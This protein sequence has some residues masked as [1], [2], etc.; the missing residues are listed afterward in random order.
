VLLK[1]RT[2]GQARKEFLGIGSR[3]TRRLLAWVLVVGALV[4]LLVS[5]GEAY[6]TYRERLDYLQAHL[7]SIGDFALPTLTK[8][9]WAYD[10]EQ[11][12][13]QLNAF[14]RLP[15]VDG[16][17]L[18]QSDGDELRVGM[19]RL[20]EDTLQRRFEIAHVD[21]GQRTA[22]GSL[23][24]IT[25]LH[26]DRA[27]LMR[28]IA[29]A[30]AGNALIILVISII[31]ALL[32]HSIVRRRLLVIARE[33]HSTTPEELRLTPPA[34]PPVGG[35]AAR[36]EFDDL[37]ASIV[38][39]KAMTGEA[40]RGLENHNTALSG[41][42][43]SLAESKNLLRAVVDTVP[44]RV[45]WKD[46]DL[47]YLGCNPIF[48][49]DAGKR[50]P[51]E[52]VGRDDYQMGWAAQAELY[53]SDDRNIL[54]SGES[55]LGYEEPQ[56][57]PDGKTI[58][59][60]TSK[61]PLRDLHG[62][63][64]GVLGIY[65]DITERKNVEDQLRASNERFRSL[66]ELSPDATL[67]IEN[68]RITAANKAAVQL[69]GHAREDTLLHLHLS[70]ISLSTQPDGKPSFDK[71]EAMMRLAE[72]QGMHRFEWTHAGYDGHP[73]LT[74][75]TLSLI[76]MQEHEALYTV[77]RD[78]SDRQRAEE[79]ARASE[80]RYR[81]LAENSVDWIWAIGLDGQHTYSNTR[82]LQLIGMDLAE[83][84][85]TDARTL[86]HPDDQDLF[87]RT[88]REACAS[89]EGWHG[90]QI[91]WRC[92]DG[93]YRAFESNS[94]PILDKDG[95]MVGFQGVDRDITERLATETELARHRDNL[96]A[97]V[98]TR[99][100]ELG[101]AK[102]AAEAA[103]V[104]KSAFLANMSHEIR[105]PLNAITGMAHLIRRG[106][107]N[108]TQAARLETLETASDHLLNIINAILEL[109]K[110]EA[111][112]LVLDHVPVHLPTI[113]GNVV[114]IL[115]AQASAKQLH[116]ITDTEAM[117]FDLVGDPVRLQQALLNYAGNALKF[118]HA[119]SISLRA[120]RIAETADGVT[121]RI[122]VEDT[123]IGIDPETLARLFNVF[124][125]A[126][127]STTRRYGGTGLG[128]AI[129]KRLA[130]LMG[131]DAG[132]ESQPG[133]GSTF[134]FSVRLKKAQAKPTAADGK[135]IGDPD[136]VLKRDHAGRRILVAEDEPINREITLTLLDDAGL[137]ADAAE[138]GAEAVDLMAS[139]HYDLILMDMQMPRMDGLEATRRIR[140][141]SDGAA[142]PIIA[143]TANAFIEDKNLCLAAGMNDFLAKPVNP[144]ELYS[145]L[146][147]WLGSNPS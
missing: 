138:D 31:I 75:V 66:F 65:D 97:M 107:L 54:S 20:S 99:T 111:G 90:I 38:S 16:V 39:L 42:M 124:E 88:F 100:E 6:L 84:M 101:R 103:N 145:M 50:S 81:Q 106:G 11:V 141:R 40:L 140:S 109:S 25:D 125:Q 43:E 143:M 130:H 15:E 142:I 34:E 17:R 35:G 126:D 96:E 14:T 57:T 118:T 135:S 136:A 58:W 7:D 60:R 33:L 102:E 82:G 70:D 122:E 85:S 120:R 26:A 76:S 21:A 63:I 9:L 116:L 73:L 37:A 10:H 45:F 127:N 133:A 71:A 19:D 68:H 113:F 105:T 89:G 123:G 108:P 93:S 146:L 64:I 56:T 129:T 12:A 62:D 147:K 114:S 41:L 131:G 1:T 28:N 61:L 4:S 121:V 115:G 24:L 3:V 48:A 49:L 91:R 59:L 80:S 55:N 112:K 36:D 144:H 132:A 77:V 72:T 46:R 53:R 78:I 2:D 95:R 67:I 134:W 47:R 44:M 52:V 8:S 51:D 92:L 74:Q 23:T 5:S 83:L 98:A 87:N 22:L 139:G 110:I 18:S 104:A 119:G 94:S 13:L 137:A 79:M 32:Y 86:V 117:P 27:Q 128:L 29:L 69:F 30:F